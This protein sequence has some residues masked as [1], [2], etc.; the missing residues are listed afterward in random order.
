MA[1]MYTFGDIMAW[2]VNIEQQGEM[3]YEKALNVSTEKEAQ[4]LFGYLRDQEIKHARR[5]AQ[6]AKRPRRRK[7]SFRAEGQ[8]EDL[9]DAFMRGMAFFDVSEVR[10]AAVGRKDTLCKLLKLAMDV[11]INTLIFYQ[12][13]KEY[14]KEKPAKDTLNLIIR[15]EEKHLI[16]LKNMRMEKDPLYAGLSPARGDGESF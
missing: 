5:F 6:L 9:L 15:E 11:E 12:K 3:F 13:I 16:K 8:F 10:G 7:G 4:K 2:A 1:A 14:M